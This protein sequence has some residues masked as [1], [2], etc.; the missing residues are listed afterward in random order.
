MAVTER[1]VKNVQR[2]IIHATM[3]RMHDVH[4]VVFELHADWVPLIVCAH[5]QT[6][7]WN[8]LE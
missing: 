3:L 7:I 8:S 2:R 4:E 1:A 5:F 6:H